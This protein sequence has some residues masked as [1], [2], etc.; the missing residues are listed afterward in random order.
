MKKQEYIDK[1]DSILDYLYNNMK[2]EDYLDFIKSNNDLKKYDYVLGRIS[3][4]YLPS[5]SLLV[6]TKNKLEK[7]LKVVSDKQEQIQRLKKLKK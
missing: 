5:I 1:I 7:V 6:L 3:I 4:N 2:Y